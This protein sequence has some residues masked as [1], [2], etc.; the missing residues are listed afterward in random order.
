MEMYEKGEWPKDFTRIVM[1]P[2][3]KK[4]NAVECG[5]YRT[6]SLIA[7]ASKIMLKI[8][9]KRIEA[10]AKDYIGRNQFGF[11]TGCGTR[12]AIGVMRMLCERSLE[13]GNDVYICFVDFEKAFD[14]VNWVKMMSIL[15]NLGVD[16]RDRRMIAEL[17]MNQEAVV[18]IEDDVSD[19]GIIGRGVR[20]GCPISPLLF[21]IYAEAM[22]AE[23]LEEVKEGI[24]VGGELLKDV[25]F[26]DDQGM[27]ASSNDG[28]QR[29]IDSLNRAAGRYNMKINIKKT[30]TMVV[31]R[32]GGGIVDIQLDGKKVEQ[33]KK[34]RYLGSMIS[35][36]GRCIDDVKS[37]IGMA[38]DAFYKTK[39][40]LTKSLS[41]SI[42]KRMVKSLIW[43]VA[44]YGC[45]TWTMRKEESDR[46][47]AFEMWI[48]RRMEKVSWNDKK[49]NE[50]ILTLVEEERCMLEVIAKRKKAWIGHVLRGDGL[51][52]LVIE[53]RME[54]KRPRGRPRI[55]M[56][57]DIMMG[58]YGDM[59]RMALD[60][61]SW[62]V[63]VPRTCH[64]AEN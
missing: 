17:Y 16:W 25:R 12:D 60:R 47:A 5:D 56:M 9:T 64:V 44:L 23:A 19:P 53:G 7:H 14:R 57:D 26:A 28:L 24:R 22:M 32:K 62:R 58:S 31:S 37:R 29:L 54:G 15:R 20:Q 52:K 59:K 41:K 11:R 48:W 39:E 43:P 18:R 46:L 6:I 3:E 1:I 34:F 40:L 4:T 55:G 35:E 36:D 27:I 63:W 51:L 8:L 45:E 61:D 2:I 30:K 49:T 21:S 13:H 10:K 38:K 50:E 33:V 42:K